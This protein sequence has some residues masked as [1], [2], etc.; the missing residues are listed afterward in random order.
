MEK[1]TT[2]PLRPPAQPLGPKKCDCFAGGEDVSQ[3]RSDSS[4][5]H[6]RA[7]AQRRAKELDSVACLC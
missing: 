6:G 5:L 2:P 3:A 1:N 7:G 4:H